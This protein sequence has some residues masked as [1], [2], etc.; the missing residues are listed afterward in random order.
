[1]FAFIYDKVDKKLNQNDRVWFPN[2]KCCCDYR[3]VNLY[4]V[5]VQAVSSRARDQRKG[6][7]ET[8]RCPANENDQPE[9]TSA[10]M[11][12]PIKEKG[13]NKKRPRKD[14]DYLKIAF[15]CYILM[16]YIEALILCWT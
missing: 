15:V 8:I 2:L 4:L 9:S 12:T 14:P 13:R 16:M 6:A 11:K 10:P 3:K 1:M 7:P 5:T